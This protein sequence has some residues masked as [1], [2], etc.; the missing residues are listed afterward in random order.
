MSNR[1]N[2]SCILVIYYY[3][4]L[5]LH[6]TYFTY[7]NPPAFLSSY[8]DYADYINLLTFNIGFETL[9]RFFFLSFTNRINFAAKSDSFY[10][11]SYYKKL[12]RC[13]S[14]IVCAKFLNSFNYKVRCESWQVYYLKFDILMKLVFSAGVSWH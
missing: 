10:V 3:Y 13:I 5:L 7:S 2:V 14:N 1:F 4:Y 12:H 9:L 11:I 8:Y 6:R